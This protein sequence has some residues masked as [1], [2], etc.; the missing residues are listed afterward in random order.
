[1]NNKREDAR[2]AAAEARTQCAK[3][4]ARTRTASE[5]ARMQ[6]AAAKAEARARPWSRRAT[7]RGMELI[8]NL[9]RD[10]GGS[11]ATGRRGS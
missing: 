2:R 11:A 4:Q 7:T 6:A 9:C 1:M 10:G 8:L 3:A 5:E